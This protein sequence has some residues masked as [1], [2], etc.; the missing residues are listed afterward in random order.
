M[1]LLAVGLTGLLH[2]LCFPDFDLG[3]LAWGFLVPLH[4]ALT[5]PTIRADRAA[6]S[7][8]RVTIVCTFLNRRMIFPPYVVIYAL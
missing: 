7:A 4:W 2:P 8:T 3:W 5:G 1:R 6:I